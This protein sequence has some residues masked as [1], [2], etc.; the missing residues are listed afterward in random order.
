MRKT[1]ELHLRSKSS[2]D[3]VFKGHLLGVIE[4]SLSHIC[5][6]LPGC[7]QI[8]RVFLNHRRKLKFC[9]VDGGGTP[10]RQTV[11]LTRNK[12]EEIRHLPLIT[13]EVSLT[14]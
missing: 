12:T 1:V 5:Q 2:Y 13:V 14:D 9:C 3:A 7:Y 10:L 6:A 11:C 4:C 8:N